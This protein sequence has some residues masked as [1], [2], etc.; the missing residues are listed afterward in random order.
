[1]KIKTIL[2]IGGF[3]KIGAVLCKKLLNMRYEVI[4]VDTGSLDIVERMNLKQ[5]PNF[6]IIDTDL[7]DIPSFGVHIDYIFH[8]A[9]IDKKYDNFID[10]MRICFECTRNILNIGEI[11]G[12][13]VII[14]IN[15]NNIT[16]IAE[17]LV[18][19]YSDNRNVDACIIYVK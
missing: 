16:H 8:M 18:K 6:H 12:S 10:K 9:C 3:T 5:Y 19:Y 7:I 17:D 1:M 2:V 11:H 15:S 4:C 13:S 14:A